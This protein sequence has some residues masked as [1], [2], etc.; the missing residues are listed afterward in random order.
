MK[1]GAAC[2]L[3]SFFSFVWG[4]AH[5]DYNTNPLNNSIKIDYTRYEINY[6]ITITSNLLI[7]EKSV[8]TVC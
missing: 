2:S 7:L 1:S 3:S 5:E 4:F 6:E 8:K